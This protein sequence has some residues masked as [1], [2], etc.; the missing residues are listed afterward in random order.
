[1]G[2]SSKD[3]PAGT[4]AASPATQPQVMSFTMPDS[5]STIASQL[6]QG[7]LLDAIGNPGLLYQPVSVPIINNPGQLQSWMLSQGM[8]FTDNELKTV[9]PPKAGSAVSTPTTAKPS[10]GTTSTPAARKN[11]FGSR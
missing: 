2:G 10:G 7:G 11:I 9:N 5:G 4:A 8:P 6:Q 1:M 3:K